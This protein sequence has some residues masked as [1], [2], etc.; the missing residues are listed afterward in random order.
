M[1]CLCFKESEFDYIYKLKICINNYFFYY[2]GEPCPRILYEIYSLKTL[3]DFMI[4]YNIK[5]NNVLKFENVL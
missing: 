4:L 1:S 3:R 2:L 5:E